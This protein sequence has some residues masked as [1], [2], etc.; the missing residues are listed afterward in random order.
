MIKSDLCTEE[1]PVRAYCK[2]SGRSLKLV[3]ARNGRARFQEGKGSSIEGT[4]CWTPIHV[5]RR[6]RLRGYTQLSP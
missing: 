1:F 2:A 6:N 3:E 5:L 4:R